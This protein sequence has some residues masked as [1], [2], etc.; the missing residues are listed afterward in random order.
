M[1]TLHA[2]PADV[3]PIA[4]AFAFAV[5][6]D[7]PEAAADDFELEPSQ[8]DREWWAAQTADDDAG[9][10]PDYDTMAGESAALDAHCAGLM[11][12]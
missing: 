11:A 1:T 7:A 2:N 8:E 10:E 6:D 12:W 9:P 3:N 4:D 5:P